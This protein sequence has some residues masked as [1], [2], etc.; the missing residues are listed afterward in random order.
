MDLPVQEF[1]YIHKKCQV[2][3]CKFVNQFT[4]FRNEIMFKDLERQG[5][6]GAM[7]FQSSAKILL[8]NAMW[9]YDELSKRGN[10]HR[11]P[12]VRLND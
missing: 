12:F 10:S 7:K 1:Y 5:D 4:L 2:H 3:L 8:M 9:W 11:Y 6:R